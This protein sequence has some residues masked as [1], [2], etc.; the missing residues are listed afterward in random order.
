MEG[1]LYK[2]PN[3][4]NTTEEKTNK[5]APKIIPLPEKPKNTKSKK[6]FNKTVTKDT[7]GGQEQE[8]KEQQKVRQEEQKV[9]QEQKEQEEQQEVEQ[10]EQKK[11]KKGKKEPKNKKKPLTDEERAEGKRRRLEALAR[12]RQKA[13]ILRKAKK[14]KLKLL[15]QLA[16]AG[17]LIPKVTQPPQKIDTDEFSGTIVDKIMSKFDEMKLD[18]RL[19]PDV[20]RMIPGNSIVKEEVQFNSKLKQQLIADNPENEALF[21]WLEFKKDNK[22]F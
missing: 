16:E 21:E 3:L 14:E 8:E 20:K 2:E 1:L 4:M 6:N 7:L 19:D 5:E 11:Q 12:G 9:E 15:E 13:N 18:K 17:K 10:E 22:F